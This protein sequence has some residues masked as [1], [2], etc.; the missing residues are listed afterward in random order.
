MAHV[1][2]GSLFIVTIV[3]GVGLVC[4]LCMLFTNLITGNFSDD[5]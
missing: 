1:M 4:C 5:P 3:Q 2:L